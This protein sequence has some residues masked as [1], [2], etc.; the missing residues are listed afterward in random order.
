MRALLLLLTLTACGLTDAPPARAEVAAPRVAATADAVHERAVALTKKLKGKGFTIAELPPFVIIGD[1]KPA[2]VKRRVETVRWTMKLLRQDYFAKDPDELI[3]IWLFADEKTYRAGAKKY[4]DDDPSTPY[5]YYSPTD[6]A[7]IM[8]IGPGAGTLV[9][10]LVHPYMEANFP[11]CPS[12]FNEGLASLYEYAVEVDGH[13]HGKVNWRLRGLRKELKSGHRRSFQSLMS[14]TTD[15]FYEAP[16]DTYAQARYLMYY[17]QQK[18]LL[19]DYYA[20]FLAHADTDPTGYA[21]LL[22]VLGRKDM[23][24]FQKEW[25][26][27]VL[28]LPDP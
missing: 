15:E 9:H 21:S 11:G 17:L 2:K 10:E 12:W 20:H 27:W 24:V 7:M 1:E 4:F 26:A 23:D 22:H 5:G 13:I 14:T 6:R 19:R 28:A 3:E 8:N 25:E 16:D 18:G